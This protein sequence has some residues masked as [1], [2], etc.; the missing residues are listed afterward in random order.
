M[1][2]L[3]TFCNRNNPV[4]LTNSKWRYLFSIVIYFRDAKATMQNFFFHLLSVVDSL[5]D[6]LL[7]VLFVTESSGK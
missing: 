4:E 7:T 3:E 1:F 6:L 5:D 2:Y